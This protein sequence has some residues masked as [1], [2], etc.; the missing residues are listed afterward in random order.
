ML[1]AV[2]VSVFKCIQIEVLESSHLLK[3][4]M[5]V[6]HSLALFKDLVLEKAG[7]KVGCE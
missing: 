5:Q 3:V 6:L 4:N 7:R 2:E 1:A